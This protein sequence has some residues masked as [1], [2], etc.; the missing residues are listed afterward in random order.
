MKVKDSFEEN[1]DGG[2]E[3]QT[4][5]THK[6]YGQLGTIGKP[7]QIIKQQQDLWGDSNLKSNNVI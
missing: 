2:K 7:K 6:E 5:M 1:Y 3:V 4:E